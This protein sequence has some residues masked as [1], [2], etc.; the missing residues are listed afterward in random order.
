MVCGQGSLSPASR[1]DVG[2]LSW[3]LARPGLS[4]TTGGLG[5]IWA[6]GTWW[7][8]AAGG[9]RETRRDLPFT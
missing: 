8:F 1:L 4:E 7:L 5:K 3:R 2:L 6:V 9:R